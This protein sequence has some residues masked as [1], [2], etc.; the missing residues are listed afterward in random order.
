MKEEILKQ[1]PLLFAINKEQ[2]LSRFIE[3]VESNHEGIRNILGG[4]SK[5][6]DIQMTFENQ[7]DK[8]DLAVVSSIK[9][10]ILTYTRLTVSDEEIIANK[11]GRISLS[12]HCLRA[13]DRMRKDGLYRQSDVDIRIRIINEN[14]ARLHR[15]VA[16][17]GEY[18]VEITTRP[19]DFLK[20]G[21][22]GDID[23]Q[24]CFGDDR[25]NRHNK[26]NLGVFKDS[27]V[28][29]IYRDKNQLVGRCFGYHNNNNAVICNH[30][31]YGIN[32][33]SAATIGRHIAKQFFG[34]QSA[35]YIPYG[36]FSQH[37]TI[38]KY[39]Y[40]NPQYITFASNKQEYKPSDFKVDTKISSVY[41]TQ[42][43]KG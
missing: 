12:K 4:D 17:D 34:F 6:I 38:A 10:Y 18:R 2:Y 21:H 7:S 8:Y 3:E 31:T 26:F 5:E 22:Y 43:S 32:K 19:K 36:F 35:V 39:V 33:G 24:S 9:T 40:I 25:C 14:I 27:F 11:V 37:A 41:A 30:Y 1:H 29:K 16:S 20:L 28:I 13:M 15:D 23:S 42:F